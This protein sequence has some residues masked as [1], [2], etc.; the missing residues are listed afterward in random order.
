MKILVWTVTNGI[1]Q[2]WVGK[3]IFHE[4]GKWGLE[5]KNEEK[6]RVW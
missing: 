4:F 6:W 1:Y 5:V 3:M 2:W